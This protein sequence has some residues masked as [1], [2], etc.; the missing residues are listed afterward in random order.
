MQ[1]Y[2]QTCSRSSKLAVMSVSRHTCQISLSSSHE[3][4]QTNLAIT[5]LSLSLIHNTIGL[6]TFINATI[7][8]QISIYSIGPYWYLLACTLTFGKVGYNFFSRSL[9]SRIQFCTPDFKIRGAAHTS[10]PNILVTAHCM[11]NSNYC[12][13]YGAASVA[14]PCSFRWANNTRCAIFMSIV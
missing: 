10:V 13:F 4:T 11:R 8:Q 14:R 1:I 6:P 2:M 3:T 9:R 12:Y 7:R 5:E